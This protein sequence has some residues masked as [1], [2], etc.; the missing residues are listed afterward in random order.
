MHNHNPSPPVRDVAISLAPVM[1]GCAASFDGRA[2]A[3][4]GHPPQ[5]EN[6]CYLAGYLSVL[7]GAAQ[8]AVHEALSRPLPR[9]KT[10]TWTNTRP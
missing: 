3:I 1:H 7:C 4:A 10:W 6:A 9:P 5:C 2:H 8:T